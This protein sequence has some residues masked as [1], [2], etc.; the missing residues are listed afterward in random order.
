VGQLVKKRKGLFSTNNE[1]ASL[2][3]IILFLVP[4][5][6]PSDYSA[7]AAPNISQLSDTVLHK[8]YDAY[9]GSDFRWAYV[10]HINGPAI[11]NDKA[12]QFLAALAATHP[13]PGAEA[14]FVDPI[15]SETS[16]S[17]TCVIKTPDF[18]ASTAEARSAAIERLASWI[19]RAVDEYNRTYVSSS[20]PHSSP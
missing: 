2:G 1:K 14:F 8:L 3:D 20:I 4:S 13:K 7:P 5:E 12:I 10:A 9:A 6:K 15:G 16:S 18:A 11:E 19:E 17:A